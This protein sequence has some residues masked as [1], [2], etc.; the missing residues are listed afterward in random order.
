MA[1][2]KA[3]G[4]THLGRDSRPKFLGVKA[5]AGETVKIGS[6]IIRQRGSGFVAGNNVKTGRDYTLYSAI[7]GVV[8]FTAKRK[9]GYDNKQRMVKIVNV[10]EAVP[11]K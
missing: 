5:A 10:L 6:V 9:K 11:K 7:N 3:A 2:T 4:G 8:S 1:K